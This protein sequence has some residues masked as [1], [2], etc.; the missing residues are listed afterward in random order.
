MVVARVGIDWDLERCVVIRATHASGGESEI[1]RRRVAYFERGRGQPEGE[2][3][4]GG[5]FASGR[6]A[7]LV[8]GGAQG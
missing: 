7:D 4:S 1:G 8:S 5:D 2:R 3:T 6:V